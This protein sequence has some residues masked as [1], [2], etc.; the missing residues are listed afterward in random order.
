LSL[1]KI[2]F[3]LEIIKNSDSAPVDRIVYTLKQY[4]RAIMT[5]FIKTLLYLMLASFSCATLTSASQESMATV[6]SSIITEQTLIPL[7]LKI[8]KKATRLFKKKSFVEKQLGNTW[9]NNV[10]FL[11]SWYKKKSKNLENQP[12]YQPCLNAIELIT[13]KKIIA[14]IKTA[15][16][17]DL[18]TE[19][20]ENENKNRLNQ[21][22][23]ES[24][25]YLFYFQDNNK[26]FPFRTALTDLF[27]QTI[28]LSNTKKSASAKEKTIAKTL[29]Q[30]ITEIITYSMN[31]SINDKQNID[32]HLTL[33]YKYLYIFDLHHQSIWSTKKL[34]TAAAITTLATAATGYGIHKMGFY[35]TIKNYFAPQQAG[36]PP[37]DHPV[38]PP[39]APADNPPL[40]HPIA[41]PV[42]ENPP[43]APH[44]INPLIP[45]ESDESEELHL[46]G[47]IDISDNE[48]QNNSIIP[49]NIKRAFLDDW[50]DLYNV[51]HK[52]KVPNAN[53]GNEVKVVEV[54]EDGSEDPLISVKSEEKRTVL[55][56]CN[57]ILETLNDSEITLPALL[58]ALPQE[59][60]SMVK[61]LQSTYQSMNAP[62]WMPTLP[63]YKAPN[64]P[65]TFE[66][67]LQNLTTNPED[68]A[69]IP[70]TVSIQEKRLANPLIQGA[71][72][73]VKHSDSSLFNSLFDPQIFT[74]ESC[75]NFQDA[76]SLALTP[77]ANYSI[78]G[79]QFL[80]QG[81]R[82]LLPTH[83]EPIAG[84]LITFAGNTANNF[85]IFNQF[86]PE[87]YSYLPAATMALARQVAPRTSALALQ[88]VENSFNQIS[89]YVSPEQIKT[90]A[91]L[92]VNAYQLHKSMEPFLPE[93]VAI[94]LTCILVTSKLA[95]E[96]HEKLPDWVNETLVPVHQTCN[97]ISRGLQLSTLP[98]ISFFTAPFGYQYWSNGTNSVQT[99]IAL[100]AVTRSPLVIGS[101][102]MR[103]FLQKKIQAYI[104]AGENE[105]EKARR[106]AVAQ[107]MY[108]RLW[109]ISRKTV[110]NILDQAKPAYAQK[111]SIANQAIEQSQP[112]LLALQAPKEHHNEENIVAIRNPQT[113]PTESFLQRTYNA[114]SS[115][116]SFATDPNDFGSPSLI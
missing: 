95:Q 114:I 11:A 8:D 87:E 76:M 25:K 108:H 91:I 97:L 45:E 41:N 42:I 70:G 112:N 107:N 7:I 62:Q 12:L 80:H 77:Q 22:L 20:S 19:S 16:L 1:L 85:I 71:L 82:A 39:V 9:I 60:Q 72:Q 111:R 73:A 6:P 37:L 4:K 3:T 28:G 84:P 21:Q 63:A 68:K 23:I 52:L 74:S 90:T 30:C 40:D 88:A 100:V 29:L 43:V 86:F 102:L 83:S 48:E 17:H 50:K 53:Q 15:S 94:P 55:D 78:Q 36:N 105:Q 2:Y 75:Q 109:E 13:Y 56:R 113:Q 65:S 99:N 64:I 10:P 59:E 67:T 54:H 49:D 51:W 79:I 116:F 101:I 33:L 47:T 115:Y 57:S 24:I 18:D 46:F 96:Q 104:D 31:Q 110:S 38:N 106:V 32:H 35:N 5:H 98:I 14:H 44:D 66:K 26:Q 93:K 92:T 89:P 81:T 69:L 27:L 34:I 61:A 103:S 58:A